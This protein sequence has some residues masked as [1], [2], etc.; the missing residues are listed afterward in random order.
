MIH[1]YQNN[2]YNIVLDVNS[3]CVHVVD[4]FGYDVIACL[5][6]L[7]ENQTV[8]TLKSPDTWE[9]LKKSL[10]GQYPEADLREMLEDVTELVEAGQLFAPDVYESY[11]GEVIKR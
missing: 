6:G 8:E 11:T 5:N 4:Q 1:Q 10:G 2:G 9:E 3:G 7:N